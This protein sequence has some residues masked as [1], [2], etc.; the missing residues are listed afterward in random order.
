MSEV[1]G[2][3]RDGHR[4]QSSGVNLL[5]LKANGAGSLCDYLSCFLPGRANKDNARLFVDEF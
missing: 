3:E 2:S 4:K 5:V 1:G